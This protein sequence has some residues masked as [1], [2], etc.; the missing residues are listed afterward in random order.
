[1]V[2][3]SGM[4]PQCGHDVMAAVWPMCGCALT[5]SC[6]VKLLSTQRCRGCHN[7]AALVVVSEAFGGGRDMR[8]N[9][10]FGGRH[11]SLRSQEGRSD[12]TLDKGVAPDARRCCQR[13]G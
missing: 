3:L 4:V 13:G 6:W 12:D 9:G 7:V 1:V 8:S 10:H 2:V 11:A 5:R